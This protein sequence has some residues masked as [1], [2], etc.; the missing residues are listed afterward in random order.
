MLFCRQA[1]FVLCVVAG[2]LTAVGTVEDADGQV[3][4]MVKECRELLAADKFDEAVEKVKAALEVE[5]A[6]LRAQGT[7]YNV[8]SDVMRKRGD[9]VAADKSLLKACD[10]LLKAK[11]EKA[12]K[13]VAARLAATPDGKALLDGYRAKKREKAEQQRKAA[14]VSPGGAQSAG[15]S[16]AVSSAWNPWKAGVTPRKFDPKAKR[17]E[18]LPWTPDDAAKMTG[19]PAGRGWNYVDQTYQKL[20][21]KFGKQRALNWYEYVLVKPTKFEIPRDQMA[22]AWNYYGFRAFNALDHARVLQTISGL[23]SCGA[24]PGSYFSYRAMPSVRLF[25]DL[26]TFPKDV[27]TIRIPTANPWVKGTRKVSARSFG[28]NGADATECIRKALAAPADIVVFEKMEGPWRIGDTITVPADRTLLFEDGVRVVGTE[29]AQVAN[30]GKPMFLIDGKADNVALIGKGDVQIGWYPDGATRDRYVKEEGGTGICIDGGQHVL[31]RDLRVCECGCDGITLGGCHRMTMDI[32]IEN[33]VLDHNA[34]QGMSLC[35]G[36]D[37][38]IHNVEFTHTVGA[39]PMAGID[40]EPSI[41]EVQA[42]SNVY[43]W[44]CTFADNRG[45]NI[46]F[47]E[48]ST[49]PVT[50]LFKNCRVGSHDYGAVSIAALCGL[51]QGNGTDAPSD[52]IFDGCRIEGTSWC[53]PVTIAGANLFHVTFRNCDVVQ[54][55]GNGGVASPFRFLMN[56]E[57]YNPK[58]GDR[59]W[60]QKE[61]SIAFDGTK[62]TGWKGAEP[63]TFSDKTGH[64]SV[65]RVFGRLTMNGRSCDMTKY[66]Y[67]APDF[68]FEEPPWSIDPAELQANPLAAS[69]KAAPVAFHWRAAWWVGDLQYELFTPNGSGGFNAAVFKEKEGPVARAGQP[70]HAFRTKCSDG[71]IRIEAPTALYFEVPPGKGDAILKI[72]NLHHAEV[73]KGRDKVLEKLDSSNLKDGFA[74]VKLKQGQKPQIYGVRATIGTLEFKLFAPCS[75]IVAADPNSVP[76]RREE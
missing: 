74:Y 18:E 45:N 70:G 7:I 39:Q 10:L 30:A 58:S 57:Y 60:Y 48:S 16:A 64:Y 46:V 37:V 21:E 61:G 2:A 23:R 4:A 31:I 66:R 76:T 20:A 62:V 73:L 72:V 51:Y 11:E 56:R 75:G 59:T 15:R 17:D 44:D 6:G 71:L 9:A 38:Y 33:V 12:A 35:N 8:Y 13:G 36:A 69:A 26:K 25:E 27:A 29:A 5:G 3:R 53:A 22:N 50:V 19:V 32:W 42:T 1:A 67:A 55:K 24:N 40:F 43:I 47:S 68:Q 65:N 63:L 52:I 49:Y 41:Q 28:W 34:R 54:V 14:L